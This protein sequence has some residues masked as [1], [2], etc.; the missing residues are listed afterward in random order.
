[1]MKKLMTIVAALTLTVSAL[2]TVN[3][4]NKKA[5]KA[6]SVEVSLDYQRQQIHGSNQF[7]VWVENADGQVVKTLYVTTFTSKGRKRGDEK[8]RRGYTFRPN[9]V[10]TWVQHVKAEER[11]D[12]EMDAVTGATPQASGRQT[13]QWDFTDQNGKK[14]KKG[15]YKICVEATVFED[16]IVLYTGTFSVGDSIGEIRL[17]RSQTKEDADHKDMITNV[18]ASLK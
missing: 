1:M 12:A 10:P 2:A 7:A 8:P 3:V 11:S 6:R 14:V 16:A 18:Q 4:I 17:T 15:L 13:Y 5:A 9:C